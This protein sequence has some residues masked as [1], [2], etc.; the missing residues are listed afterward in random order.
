[1]A[2]SQRLLDRGDRA[3]E[4]LR[5]ATRVASRLPEHHQA[6]LPQLVRCGI[7]QP[8]GRARHRSMRTWRLARAREIC[9]QARRETFAARS[10]RLEA[11][12][13]QAVGDLVAAQAALDHAL[14]IVRLALEDEDGARRESLW[15]ESQ[16]VFELGIAIALERGD[17]ETSARSS[18]GG[19]LPG[20]AL[21]DRSPA[22]AGLVA[23]NDGW[24]SGARPRS[25]PSSFWVRWATTFSGGFSSRT[26]TTPGAARSMPVRRSMAPRAETTGRL[27]ARGGTLSR[28]CWRPRWRDCRPARASS[29]CRTASSFAIPY[30]ALV[31]PKTDTPL[32]ESREL[33]LRMSLRHAIAARPSVE[34]APA[35]LLFVAN[36]TGDP[37]FLAPLEGA[38]LE[39]AEAAAVWGDRGTSLVGREATL[40]N[41]RAWLDKSPIVHL[42]M[43]AVRGPAPG[44]VSLA[45]AGDGGDGGS[46]PP[47]RRHHRHDATCSSSPRA[48]PVDWG[49]RERPWPG[50]CS[51]GW[52]I[53]R[54][55]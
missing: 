45:F 11:R 13:H 17:H 23:L 39:I 29:S 2:R 19:A 28:R 54:S 26:E 20:R 35:R 1:M 27:K 24:R 10:W 50:R 31:D 40:A 53:A 48:R 21:E 46:R 3:V 38:E 37:T 49:S 12:I 7:G 32:I 6:R 9:P 4:R 25:R 41:A 55:P 30:A 16:R 18:R 34:P 52:R 47:L 22:R 51:H 36:P 42:A 33:S 5:E 14:R 43:H 15:E 8:R 44:D